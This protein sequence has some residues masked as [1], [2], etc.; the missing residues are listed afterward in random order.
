ML[1]TLECDLT[2]GFWVHLRLG[3][4]VLVDPLKVLTF[5]YPINLDTVTTGTVVQIPN[6]T[7]LKK[8]ALDS[9]AGVCLTPSHPLREVHMQQI[10]RAQ[11]TFRVGADCVA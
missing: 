6:E 11:Y 4:E 9:G 5:P 10:Q 3:L 2:P 7:G 1:R 8:S